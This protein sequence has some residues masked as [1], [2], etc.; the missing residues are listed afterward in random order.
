MPQPR[1]RASCSRVIHVIALAFKL[2]DK[3]EE[4]WKRDRVVTSAYEGN[5]SRQRQRNAPRNASLA[6]G[7][8]NG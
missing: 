8:G 1:S 4:E 3:G 5:G 7:R 6:P 2:G